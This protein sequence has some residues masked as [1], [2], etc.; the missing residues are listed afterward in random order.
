MRAHS[1][2]RKTY[3]ANSSELR[4]LAR[5]SKDPVATLKHICASRAFWRG[6]AWSLPATPG[7]IA[8]LD[9]IEARVKSRVDVLTVFTAVASAYQGPIPTDAA[10][11]VHRAI[12]VAMRLRAAPSLP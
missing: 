3:T 8:A 1:E 7:A 2:A 10:A 5:H 4:G 11:A 9:T 12:L 6:D